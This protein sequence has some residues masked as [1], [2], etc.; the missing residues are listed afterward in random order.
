MPLLV[1][2]MCG[3]FILLFI[4]CLFLV[5]YIFFRRN[6]FEVAVK[7]FRLVLIL[8]FLNLLYVLNLFLAVLSAKVYGAVKKNLC[9][10]GGEDIVITF[11]AWCGPLKKKR[12]E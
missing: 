3:I 1:G 7:V 12:N 9:V 8:L 4:F 11:S 6:V 10:G 2:L 5:I